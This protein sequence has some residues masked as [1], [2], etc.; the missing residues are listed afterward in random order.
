MPDCE[1]VRVRA[2]TPTQWVQNRVVNTHVTSRIALCSTTAAHLVMSPVRPPT[3]SPRVPPTCLPCVS[4]H[5]PSPPPATARACCRCDAR[6]AMPPTGV[7]V[8]VHHLLRNQVDGE[9][10][11]VR[12]AEEQLHVQ[13]GGHPHPPGPGSADQVP[14]GSPDARKRPGPLHWVVRKGSLLVESGESE[15]ATMPRL[16][17][18]SPGPARSWSNNAPVGSKYGLPFTAAAL[19]RCC[20][21]SVNLFSKERF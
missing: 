8:P 17:S 3:L 11:S 16:L 19:C 5:V 1:N 12:A 14:R 4:Q 10:L 9:V 21:L 2:T 15:R 7:R 13:L 6:G 18:G 20:R